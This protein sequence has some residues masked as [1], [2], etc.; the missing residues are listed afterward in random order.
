M[1]NN[2]HHKRNMKHRKLNSK[3]STPESQVEYVEEFDAIKLDVTRSESL[4]DSCSDDDSPRS[5]VTDLEGSR[6]GNHGKKQI[7]ECCSDDTDLKAEC[8]EINHTQKQQTSNPSLDFAVEP[9]FEDENPPP[10]KEGNDEGENNEFLITFKSRLKR[11][12]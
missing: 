12:R 4:S 2:R 11:M 5:V 10:E 9:T 1:K 3:K 6:I 8:G 7:M